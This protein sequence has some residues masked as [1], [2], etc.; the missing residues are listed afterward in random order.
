MYGQTQVDRL[1]AMAHHYGIGV[2]LDIHAVVGSQ[3]GFDNSG[4][5]EALEW[6]TFSS[7]KVRKRHNSHGLYIYIYIIYTYQ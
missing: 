7:T 2:L 6:T 3:N 4:K 1:L 5:T